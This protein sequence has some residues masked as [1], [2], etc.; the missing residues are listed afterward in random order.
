MGDNSIAYEFLSTD[1]F[2]RYDTHLVFTG[3]TRHSK[4]ILKN[5][6]ENLDKVK[7]LLVTCDKA[8]DVLISKDHEKFL[9]LVGKSWSQKKQTSSI[10]A[11]CDTICEMDYVLENNETV[12]AHKLCGAGNGGFF[13]TFSEKNELNIP[14]ECVKIEVEPNGVYGRII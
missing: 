9:Y 3:V 10:I 7:P 14:F 2:E 5:V 12:C 6:T 8:Y 11:E 4:K 1:I 13:L